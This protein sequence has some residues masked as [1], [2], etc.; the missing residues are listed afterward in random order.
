MNPLGPQGQGLLC[1]GAETDVSAAPTA[2]PW[3][4]MAM[5]RF[6]SSYSTHITDDPRH[7]LLQLRQGEKLTDYIARHVAEGRIYVGVE[8]DER[9][10]AQAI[11]AVGNSPFFYSSDFP[12]EVNN[13]TCK[14]EIEELLENEALSRADKEAIL[15]RN[16]ECFYRL[17]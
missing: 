6:H 13:D 5:E 9:F 17:T 8:G 2:I 10:L 4:L 16:A 12:H 7:E 14:E 11:D 15:C 1:G 3:L